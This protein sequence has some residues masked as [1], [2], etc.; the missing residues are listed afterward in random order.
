MFPQ[1]IRTSFVFPHWSSYHSNPSFL[2]DFPLFLFEE[3]SFLNSKLSSS[4]H[5]QRPVC[6]KSILTSPFRSPPSAI[7]Y[8]W[9]QQD[10]DSAWPFFK[11]VLK[12]VLS[13]LISLV[14][15]IK[16]MMNRTPLISKHPLRL[17]RRV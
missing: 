8:R 11:F 15:Q 14:Q 17:S 2:T 6:V 16:P 9:V 1:L 10:E 12:T 3:K 13:S 5:F 4:L 7:K